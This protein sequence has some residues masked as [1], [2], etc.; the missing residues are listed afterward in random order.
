MN[1]LLRRNRPADLPGD[2]SS[3]RAGSEWPGSPSGLN[4]EERED[5]GARDP[6][7]LPRA[8]PRAGKLA[9]IDQR[10]NLSDTRRGG[11]SPLRARSARTEAARSRPMEQHA[12]LFLGRVG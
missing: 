5:G 6:Y 11:H 12:R 2:S 4:A 3:A 10:A 8:D 7:D 9:R 1:E